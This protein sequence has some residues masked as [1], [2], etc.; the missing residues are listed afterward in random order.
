MLAEEHQDI[1]GR[2]LKDIQLSG[3]INKIAYQKGHSLYEAGNAYLLS[4]TH[5]QY[6]YQIIDN[7]Q[8]FKVQIQFS[9]HKM[10]YQCSCQSDELCSHEYA[11]FLQTLQDLSRSLQVEKDGAKKY[12]REGMM[13]RVLKE[14]LL[15]SEKEKYQIDFS[16][17]IYGEHELHTTDQ[18]TYKISFYDFEK[19][20]GYCSCLDYQTN[21]LG[22][23]KHL[24]FAFN[25]FQHIYQNKEL[26]QQFYPFIEIFRH[27]LHD[28]QLSWYYP[29]PLS[30]EMQLL[31]SDYFDTQQLYKPEKMNELHL[32]L[33]HIQDY[34]NINIRPEVRVFIEEYYDEISLKETFQNLEF[35][36]QLLAHKLYDYQ[37]EGIRFST[38]RKGSI[39]ADEIGLGKSVQA[40]GAALYKIEYLGFKNIGILCPKN[41][42]SQWELEIKKWVP[43]KQREHFIINSFENIKSQ[44]KLDFLIIDEAQKIDDYDSVLLRHLHQIQFKHILLITDSKIEKSLIKFYAMIGLIDHHL[45]TP[46]WEF[47]YK[48]CL[49]DAQDEDQII[50]YYN[51]ENLPKRLSDIYL[52]REKSTIKEQIQKLHS[53]SQINISVALNN[54]L[55]QQ[56][57]QL[58]K[59]VL[60]I[61]QKKRATNYDYLQLKN[62]IQELISL[63]RFTFGVDENEP[64]NPKLKEFHHIIK[65][66][67][68]I[69]NEEKV[70]IFVN[71]IKLQKQLK[72]VLLQER[73]AVEILDINQENFASKTQFFITTENLQSNLPGAQ[74][75]FYFHIPNKLNAITKRTEMLQSE[76]GDHSIYLLQSTPSFEDIWIHWE[77]NKSPLLTQLNSF[78]AK[79]LE[80]QNLPLRLKEELIFELKALLLPIEDEP[81]TNTQ[82]NLFGEL[83]EE[84][85]AIQKEV[86]NESFYHFFEKIKQSFAAF[87]QLDTQTQ[88]MIRQG[89]LSISEKNDEIVFRL[90]K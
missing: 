71:N 41:L 78:L 2:F 63:G 58:S 75:Y 8:D 45:L 62:F 84:K 3:K 18:K 37:W 24:M 33:D 87:E 46:L 39:L 27:P 22:T 59:Q 54:S 57:N 88:K 86:K 80:K 89:K 40:L 64:S 5:Q 50:G 30:K 81:L 12:S 11:A 44:Q 34:K 14:R 26:P 9:D 31:L 43:L 6:D 13:Q 60:N 29:N 66:K 23:C 19:K 10:D 32:F 15:R 76:I 61:L 55:L 79:G 67:L 35:N 7:Y 1:L 42:R 83:I 70:I 77:K 4:S 56:Q 49:F 69:S 52:R 36:K 51:L 25:E 38:V 16:D 21:K 53:P 17:N 48:H 68:N 65:H 28:Y 72:R 73:K 74:H 47:S 85:T 90:K 20:I 82:M